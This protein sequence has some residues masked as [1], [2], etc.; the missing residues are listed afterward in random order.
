MTPAAKMASSAPAIACFASLRRTYTRPPIQLSCRYVHRWSG[1][2]ENSRALHTTFTSRRKHVI[3]SRQSHSKESFHETRFR[4][5]RAGDDSDP[6][7]DRWGHRLQRRMVG[8]PG[9][10]RAGRYR[11]SAGLLR[12]RA[13]HVRL[14]LRHL[15]LLLVPVRRVRPVVSLPARFLRPEALGRRMGLQGWTRVWRAARDRRADAGM[16]QAGARRAAVGLGDTASAT[17]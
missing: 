9:D 15:R 11:R 4:F 10:P 13:A 2:F 12:L 5:D 3:C 14:G 1:A 8:R 16:A 6:A 17:A 7:R